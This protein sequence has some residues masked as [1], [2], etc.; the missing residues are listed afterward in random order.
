M[1]NNM[2]SSKLVVGAID[3]GTTYSGYAFSFAHD[4]EKDP[5]KIQAN[6]WIGGGHMSLK[7]PTTILFTPEKV[8]HSFGYQAEDKYADLAEE[9]IHKDWYYFRRFKMILHQKKTLSRKTL[10][11]DENKK[12]LSALHVFSSAI[13]FL[14]DHLCN[15][16]SKKMT[17]FEERDIFWMLTVPAIWTDAAK[18][19]MREAALEAGIQSDC[20]SLALEPEAA[21]IFCKLLPVD[22]LKH[23]NSTSIEAFKAGSS[24]I[25]LDLGGGTVDVTVHHLEYDGK[26]SEIA[27]ASGGAWGGTQ[28]DE[29][30]LRFLQNVFGDEVFQAF[31][32]NNTADFLEM[33]REFE[34]KKRT[35]NKKKEGNIVIRF[36]A[37]LSETYKEKC[38]KPLANHILPGHLGSSVQIKRDKIHV[39]ANTM[40]KFFS[41]SI[42]NTS[43]HVREILEENEFKEID[44]LLL[45]G[46][47]AESEIVQESVKEAFPNKRII[48]PSEPGL[49]VLKG[50][51]LFGHN[52]S[53]M[54]SRI[55]KYTYGVEVIN[56]FVNGSDPEKYKV[57]EN[58]FYKCRYKFCPFVRAGEMV[59]VG[60]VVQKPFISDTFD[61]KEGFGIYGSTERNPKYVVD[62][63]CFRVG[64]VYFDKPLQHHTVEMRFG[65]TEI[66]LQCIFKSGD[67]K[68]I[69][70]D[71]LCT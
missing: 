55:S 15:E 54:K 1:H 67:K 13:K 30:Y 7:A 36:A 61:V 46:G 25:V 9:D 29:A 59:P 37:S 56:R 14:K 26:L 62:E 27:R 10:L 66:C 2:T 32:E 64:T 71:F 50:A 47:F 43:K 4:Y 34:I 19:F 23:N 70:F 39:D 41:D 12:A 38:S 58:G 17:E 63:S 53:V 3:F 44:T 18:K 35:I 21:S 42:T 6:H 45:V 24:Y 68:T 8:F 49:A 5:M 31:R 51:V 33:L 22:C 69:G 57:F 40:K 65:E 52:P 20:L 48:V 16:M 28:V 60:T 11:Y